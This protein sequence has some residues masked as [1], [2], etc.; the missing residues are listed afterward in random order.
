MNKE[1]KPNSEVLARLGE[2]FYENDS[3]KKTHLHFVS[4]T[5]WNSFEK[6]MDWLQSKNYLEYKTDGKDHKYH[7]TYMGREMFNM[8]LKFR[9]HIKPYKSVLTVLM[10][11]LMIDHLDD[12]VD[13]LT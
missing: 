2:A 8:I 6:Y 3:M 10:V 5:D 9:D 1:F 12:V 13:L 7:L 11:S 4:R